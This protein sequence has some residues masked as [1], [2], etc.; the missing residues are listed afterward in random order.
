MTESPEIETDFLFEASFE[1][2]PTIDLGPG[3]LGQR[4]MVPSLSGAFAGPKMRGTVLPGSDWQVVGAGNVTVLEA[5][6]ALQT[7]DGVLIRVVNKGFRRGPAEVMRR[8]AA[9]EPV[10]ASEY[11][12]RAAPAFDAPNGRYQWLNSSLFVSSGARSEGHLILRVYE[13]L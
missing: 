4:R 2:A 5:Q 10:D 6:Y 9:G 8:L 1:L 3:L 12:M 11:Y 13:V 7:D